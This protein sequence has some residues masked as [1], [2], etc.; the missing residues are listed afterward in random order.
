MLLFHP[1]IQTWSAQN[2]IKYLGKPQLLRLVQQDKVPISP[3]T[4]NRFPRYLVPISSPIPLLHLCLA[5]PQSVHIKICDFGEAKAAAGFLD[6]SIS[7]SRN[8]VFNHL[9]AGDLRGRVPCIYAAP[10]QLL[11]DSGPLSF[12]TDI[13]AL[14][15]LFHMIF[16]GATGLFSS[17]Y[18]I[19]KEVL[20]EMVRTLGKFP[21][22]WWSKYEARKEYFDEDGNLKLDSKK[23][24]P[25]SARFLKVYPGKDLSEADVQQLEMLLRKMVVYDVRQRITAQ[26]VVDSIP[27]SWLQAT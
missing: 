15:V 10:E 20:R 8:R 3:T 2:F 21:E 5:T 18:G 9:P 7:K 13:W 6:P 1:E 22:E 14:A 16:S 27:A 4:K 11:R 24:A 23:L 25:I 19:E 17:Y 26:E 12:S